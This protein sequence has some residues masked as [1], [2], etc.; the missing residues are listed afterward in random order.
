[1]NAVDPPFEYEPWQ[2][3]F[4]EATLACLELPI[5]NRE[6]LH[7]RARGGSKTYDMMNLALYCAYLGLNVIWYSASASNLEQPKL[8]FRLLVETSFLRYCV[9]KDDWLKSFIYFRGGGSLRIL[10]LTPTTAISFRADVVIYDEEA[11]MDE[12]NI[13][14]SE[15][16]TSVS[17]IGLKI[18]CS[19]PIKD[20]VFHKNY[21]RLRS[22][23]H[24]V[25]QQLV[26][27][28]RW[29]Q[30]SFLERKRAWYEAKRAKAIR[31]GTLWHFEQENECKFTTPSGHVFH[32]IQ[33]NKDEFP[34]HVLDILESRDRD[35]GLTLYSG[36]DWN[37]AEH[38]RLG[39]GTWVGNGREEFVITH[40]I[41]LGPGYSH[42]LRDQ[43]FSQITPFFTGG[44]KLCIEDGGINIAFVKW[45]MDKCDTFQNSS[46]EWHAEEW[47]TEGRNKME[48][49]MTIMNST[50][51]ID[52]YEFP[53]MAS[54]FQGAH[55]DRDSTEPKIAKNRA[56]SPHRLDTILHACSELIRSGFYFYTTSS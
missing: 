10:N 11:K 46:Q 54:E 38:H 33:Y 19:T 36:I 53:E 31:E 3:A 24:E 42:E 52:Q 51:Y 43:M 16:V 26:F 23:E 20:S 29:D 15:Y 55:W 17:Q 56:A 40:D 37:P 14:A 30:I 8:Y 12:L 41:D 25:D 18:H 28:R 45:F 13:N 48:A 32:N 9:D 50:L 6:I 21:N 47:D 49:A 39:G 27:E 22:L 44:N 1:L 2:P 34:R 7:I 4:F 5:D 35:N